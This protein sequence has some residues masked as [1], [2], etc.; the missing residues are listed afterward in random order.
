LTSIFC[1]IAE[2]SYDILEK[3]RPKLASAIANSFEGNSSDSSILH[4]VKEKRLSI[5]EESQPYY[6]PNNLENCVLFLD[7]KRKLRLVLSNC[8]C[9]I[10]QNVLNFGFSYVPSSPKDVNSH[11]ENNELLLLLRSQLAEAINLQNK[12]SLAQLHEAIKCVKLFDSRG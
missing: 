7:A 11:R 10:G 1:Y 6:D 3:Y 8:D 2:T 4:P 5:K 12:E 9:D